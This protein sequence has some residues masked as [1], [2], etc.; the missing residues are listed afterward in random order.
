MRFKINH[1]LFTSIKK[2]RLLFFAITVAFSTIT[3]AQTSKPITDY[4]A[5]SSPIVFDSKAYYL[6]WSSHP[7]ANFYKQEY[8]LKGEQAGKF[9]TMILIDA[10][11]GKQELKDVVATRVAELNKMKETNPLIN[12]E[13]IHNPKTNDYMLDF[14][15]TA[16]AEDGSIT[17]IERN[18]YR[19]KIFT[20]KAGNKSAML[21]GVSSRA[22]GSDAAKQF[23]V[24]LKQNRKDLM[25][26]VS[27]FKI[28]E[29][30]IKQ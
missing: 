24:S 22:Y 23:L 3:L 12:Y 28:P 30:K 19:Y 9:K 27:Q 4:M 26:K 21:F 16:N 14:I 11:T 7:T 13:I 10:I 17:I 18:V 15:L 20:D 29:I 5:V 2:K 6:N 8:L 1:Q 25:N